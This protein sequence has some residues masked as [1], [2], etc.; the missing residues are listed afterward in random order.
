MNSAVARRKILA[1]SAAAVGGA[2]LV[3]CGGDDDKSDATDTPGGTDAQ[4]GQGGQ[5]GD[6]SQPSGSGSQSA[7]GGGAGGTALAKTSDIP[8]GGGKIFDQQKVVVTQPSAGTFKAFSSTCTHQGCTVSS[9][10]NGTINCACHGSKFSAT[11][12]SVE[13]GPATKPLPAKQIAT[14]GDQITLQ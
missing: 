4:T 11:D 13:S 5:T 1:V 8:V 6:G 12:G 3:A 7:T 9:I 2:A 14:S 10:S